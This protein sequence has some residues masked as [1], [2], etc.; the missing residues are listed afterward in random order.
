M[1]T[2]YWNSLVSSWGWTWADLTHTPQPAGIHMDPSLIRVRL[3]SEAK[4]SIYA[5][6]WPQQSLNSPSRDLLG[7]R[8]A[9]VGR[10][11]GIRGQSDK[12]RVTWFNSSHTP[13]I[14]LFTCISWFSTL[15]AWLIEGAAKLAPFSETTCHPLLVYSRKRLQKYRGPEGIIQDETQFRSYSCKKILWP[16]LFLFQILQGGRWG[17][18]TW[19]E[20]FPFTL[21]RGVKHTGS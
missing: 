10:L 7:G 17:M 2:G 8:L 12:P 14:T 19:A 21:Q 5:R 9:P 18:A 4:A 3:L 20:T 16:V 11:W 13:C 15:T 6:S 1:G